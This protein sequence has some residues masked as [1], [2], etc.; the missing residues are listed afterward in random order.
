MQWPMVQARWMAGQKIILS[1][2]DFSSRW[3]W[4]VPPLELR[5]EMQILR[6][7]WLSFD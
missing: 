7:V 5:V 4:K 6:Y 2:S 3:V 1:A